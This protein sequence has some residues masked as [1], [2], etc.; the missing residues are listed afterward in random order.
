MYEW[1]KWFQKNREDVKED[2]SCVGSRMFI[3]AKSWIDIL[4]N[5]RTNFIREVAEVIEI[6]YVMRS[7][8]KLCFDYVSIGNI[9][10]PEVSEFSTK[11]R[12]SRPRRN[13]LK[14]KGRNSTPISVKCESHYSKR[15]PR[16]TNVSDL[17]HRVK[18]LH[19]FGFCAIV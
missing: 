3:F 6:S 13:F 4:P 7:N 2:A 14:I 17:D 1:Y 16:V 15:F 9:I 11:R 10:V 19:N 18:R 8:I 12:L 5:I